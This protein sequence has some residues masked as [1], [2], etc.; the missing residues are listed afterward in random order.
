MTEKTWWDYFDEDPREEIGRNVEGVFGEPVLVIMPRVFWA[1]LDWMETELKGDVRSFFIECEA[2][3]SPVHGCITAA[4]QNAVYQNFL[5]RERKGLSR[6]PWC[7][8]LAPHEL[9]DI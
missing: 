4:Y 3:R 5:K 1:Y 6:P 2:V 9:L 8:A 7:P